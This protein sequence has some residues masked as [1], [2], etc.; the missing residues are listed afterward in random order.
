MFCLY[1][2]LLKQ[3]YDEKLD[4]WITKLIEIRENVRKRI[5]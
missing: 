1:S 2:E 3:S 4:E 5:H